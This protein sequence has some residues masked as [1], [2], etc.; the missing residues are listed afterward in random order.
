MT[1]QVHPAQAADVPQSV[2]PSGLP[3]L[4]Q[5]V[6]LRP[7]PGYAVDSLGVGV[8]GLVVN[9]EERQL[10]AA[11]IQQAQTQL[12]AQDPIEDP[13]GPTDQRFPGAAESPTLPLAAE[14][15]SSEVSAR[16]RLS[17]PV[18]ELRIGTPIE[19]ILNGTVCLA[20]VNAQGKIEVMSVQAGAGSPPPAPQHPKEH[21]PP[22]EAQPHFAFPISCK[23]PSADTVFGPRP[24]P[25]PATSSPPGTPPRSGGREPS[26]W[27]KGPS[28]PPPVPRAGAPPA[29]PGGTP[30]PVSY[31]HLRAHET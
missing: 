19:V 17:S 5:E 13:A 6:G 22:A 29:T 15:H 14:S 20:Q 9:W 30:V 25:K 16:S 27:P 28:T 11:L 2:K 8:E 26:P 4:G 7:P 3:P 10:Q 24:P 23:A 1:A 12:A 21:Q 18:G 31:T